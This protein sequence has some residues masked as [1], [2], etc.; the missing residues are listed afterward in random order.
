MRAVGNDGRV[1]P[2]QLEPR[3]PARRGKPPAQGALRNAPALF[4]QHVHRFDGERRVIELMRAEQMQ[5]QILFVLI[6]EPLP[7]ER[8]L[9]RA[10]RV[11]R[12]R[13]PCGVSF[14]ANLPVYRVH[15]GVHRVCNGGRAG[16]DDPGLFARDPGERA[17]ENGGVLETDVRD[18]GGLGRG[19]H[20]RRIQPPAE[21]DL[22]HNGAAFLRG[23][24][25]KAH[26]GE[27][28]KLRGRVGHAAGGLL[29]GF[30]GAA[31]RRVGDVRAVNA[32]PLVHAHKVRGGVKPRFLPRRRQDR[33]KHHA[34]R[35]LAVR[36]GDVDKFQAVL[37]VSQ[38]V[39][40]L[41]HSLQTEAASLPVG[42]VDKSE[43]F[44]KLH[45]FSLPLRAARAARARTASAAQGRIR[46]PSRCTPRRAAA[47]WPR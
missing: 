47:A 22:E 30:G 8:V 33:G 42:G 12:R 2:Q 13:A 3:L 4:A 25:P 46:P 14:G 17:A 1:C 44:V 5:R 39:H 6:I 43:R 7:G 20:V 38:P 15:G 28:L 34:R 27:D 36:P 41:A 23:E 37:R 32:E 10:Q 45:V 26:R 9:P 18:N 29:H 24:I 16:L 40:Q 11:K 19:Y 31:E 35:A 21:T